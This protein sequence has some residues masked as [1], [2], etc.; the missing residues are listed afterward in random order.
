[1]EAQEMKSKVEESVKLNNATRD[2][3]TQ[4]NATLAVL[5]DKAAELTSAI[6][7]LENE[8]KLREASS[9]LNLENDGKTQFAVVDSDK[10]KK[11]I[12]LTNDKLRDAYRRLSSED[13]R[14]KL[15]LAIGE[16][17]QLREQIGALNT[18]IRSSYAVLA[19]VENELKGYRL[20]LDIRVK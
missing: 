20:L 5:S 15:A 1:M 18:S 12:P 2:S 8:I 7:V 11:V 19:S 4:A 13:L 14:T 10:G 17:A 9:F 16:Q 3:L 6:Y